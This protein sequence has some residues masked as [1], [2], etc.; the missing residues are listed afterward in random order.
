MSQLK[1]LI[2]GASG[3]VGS[4]L[5]PCLIEKHGAASI[6]AMVHVHRSQQEELRISEWAKTAMRIIE[7]DLLRLNATPPPIPEFD[8]VYHLAAFA[9]TENSEGPFEVNSHGTENLLNWLGNSLKG[10]RFIY[11]STLASI[12][13]NL[14]V[15]PA[16]EDT[17]CRP[18]TAYGQ[19]KL[20]GERII[21]RGSN[22]FGYTFT[23]LRLC[24]IVGKGFRS[25]GM[26]GVLPELLAKGSLSARLNWPGRASFL[27]VTDLA[28]ILRDASSHPGTTNRIFVLSNGESPTF[29]ELFAQIA[30]ILQLPRKRIV[31]PGW[32]WKALASVS[33]TIAKIKF[34]PYK[35]KIT[36]WRLGHLTT[37]GILADA[38]RLNSVLNPHYHP[39][40]S[41]LR[42]A[43]K[44]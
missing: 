25:G 32:L 34:V 27:C 23:I 37:D 33:W 44:N 5:I 19:T 1:F 13:R 6:T 40:E 9:E 35:M 26:F 4:Y 22:E 43:Y 21:H 38:S 31:L 20:E 17:P 10:K 39:L 11:A 42:E 28:A 8:V 24:T 41:C 3:F 29:D 2:T 30:T 36:A 12:D 14:P 18:L 16:T 15:G 7:C